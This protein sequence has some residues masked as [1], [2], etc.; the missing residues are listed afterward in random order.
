LSQKENFQEQKRFEAQISN[1]ATETHNVQLHLDLV[2][3]ALRWFAIV[4]AGVK[5]L[6][7]LFN[8]AAF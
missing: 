5:I 8:L 2:N 4:A 6:E 1:L 7:L 3:V